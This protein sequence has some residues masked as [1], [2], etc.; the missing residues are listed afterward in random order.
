MKPTFDNKS[1]RGRWERPPD[2]VDKNKQTAAKLLK[3]GS[4]IEPGQALSPSPSPAEAANASPAP[5]ASPPTALQPVLKAGTSGLKFY[6]RVDESKALSAQ[7]WATELTNILLRAAGDASVNLCLVWPAKLDSLALLHGMATLERNFDGDH[8]GLRTL[9]FPG[10]HA[11]HTALQPV[12]VDRNQFSGYYRSLW[13]T[14]SNEKEIRCKRRSASFEAMLAALNDI[15]NWQPTLAKPAFGELVPTFVYDAQRGAW[16]AV[17]QNPMERS[18]RKVTRLAHRR[19]LRNKVTSELGTALKAPNALMIIHRSARKEVWKAALSSA[20]LNAQASPDVFLLDATSVSEDRDY[21]AVRKIPEFLRYARNNGF[22]NQGALIVTDDPKTYFILRARLEEL[23]LAVR[24]HVWA[25]EAEQ[26]VLCTSAV[27]ADW[28]P[29]QKSNANFNATIVDRDASSVAMTFQRLAHDCAIDESPAQKALMTACTYVLW[30]SN[31]PVGYKDLGAEFTESGGDTFA[32]QSSAWPQV[33]YNI[34]LALQSGALNEYRVEVEAAL[35]K[36][37]TLIDNW[38][39]A[40]PMALRLLAEVKK[41]T[42]NPNGGLTL[43]LPSAKSV[44]LAYRFLSRKLGQEWSDLESRINWQTLSSIGAK[45]DFERNGWGIVFIGINRSVLRLLIS[46]PN[47]P[48]GAAILVAYRQAE[49]TL[50]TLKSMQTLEAFKPY[51]GRLGLLVQELERRL[52]EV[53]NPLNIGRLSESS[54]NFK[55][56]ETG[57]AVTTGQQSYYKFDLESGHHSYSSGWVY[58][59]NADDDPCFH[60]KSASSIEAGD[61]IFVMSDE[62]RGKIETL[63]GLNSSAINSR[64][65]PARAL[66][67]LYHD[68]VQHRCELFFTAKTRAGLAREIQGKMVELDSSA[69]QCRPERVQYWLALDDGDTRPHAAKDSRFFKLFCRALQIDESAAEQHWTFVRNARALSQ[70]L[71]RELAARYSEVIFAP[72]SAM[73]YRKVPLE[74]IQRL[75]QEAL[76]CVDRVIDVTPPAPATT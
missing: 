22:S 48:H 62:L 35:K 26:S 55:F 23:K 56:V 32:N 60:R 20:P 29:A 47:I 43:V 74:T 44:R 37:A 58:S 13:N 71:G 24:T 45:L 57:D 40:T 12:V 64:A 54:F 59:Y 76:T 17:A 18:L 70:H 66:L 41:H 50:V 33:E 30:L 11:S 61:F 3:I 69:S 7:P 68:D 36:A 51:R 4:K 14:E 34:K 75:Q 63:L 27:A 19:D 28:K 72:E 53:P 65:T 2:T 46:H 1:K 6:S 73:T 21:N 52:K 5:Q 49:S 31:L 67:K 39:D 16:S 8:K 25:A 10:T 38:E 42:R 15:R 9:L